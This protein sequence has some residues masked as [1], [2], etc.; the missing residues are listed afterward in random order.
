VRPRGTDTGGSGAPIADEAGAAP[1]AAARRALGSAARA[2]EPYAARAAGAAAGIAAGLYGVVA[3]FIIGAMVDIARLEARERRRVLSF[4]EDPSGEAPRG[5][6]E[7]LASA[8]ALAIRGDWPGTADRETRLVLFARLAS[9]AVGADPRRRREAERAAE[10]ACRCAAPDLVALARR[11]ASG[12]APR[13]GAELLAKWA[14]ALA[15]LG[16]RG[17]AAGDELRIRAALADCGIGAEEQLAARAAAFPGAKDPWTALGLSPGASAAEVKR[18]YRRL[19]RLFHP[20]LA[21]GSP[22]DAARFREVGE[23]YAALSGAGARLG[24]AGR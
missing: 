10:I 6:A 18:A 14:Y 20:D 7:A 13:P 5:D 22:E 15:A 8:A 9:E 4:L 17:L 24:G 3:G 12:S 21:G 11:M 1:S 16:G 2:A 19:S 23:A